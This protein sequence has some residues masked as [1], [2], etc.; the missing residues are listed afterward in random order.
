MGVDEAPTLGWSGAT[1]R[2]GGFSFGSETGAAVGISDV[3]SALST[4]SSQIPPMPNATIPPARLPQGEPHAQVA[5]SAPRDFS[6]LAARRV[7]P[8]RRRRS[9][10]RG[11][12]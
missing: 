7:G 11:Q 2:S 1:R 4:P 5:P 10:R 12:G 6:D 8:E 3:I 9:E